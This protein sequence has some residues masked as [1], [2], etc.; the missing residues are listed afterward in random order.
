MD[1][2]HTVIT[3]TWLHNIQW[4]DGWKFIQEGGSIRQ[5]SL[6]VINPEPFFQR[7]PKYDGQLLSSDEIARA[8]R[9]H[10]M[11]HALRFK[12]VHTA[13]RL[14]LGRTTTSDPTALWFEKGR[15]NKP[16]LKRPANTHIQFNLSY[17]ENRAM[18]GLNSSGQPIG[19]DIEWSQRLLNIETMLKACFSANEITFICAKESEMHHRFFTLWTRKE[20]ILKLTGEGIGEHL[21]HFEVLDGMYRARKQVIGRQPPDDVYLYSFSP[22]EGFIGCLASPIPITECFFY[23]L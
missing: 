1:R 13:L 20:A 10:Q 3:S 12:A 5:P 15:H 19:V 2:D 23:R 22:E 7:L 14:L 9:F 18:I 8:V 11:D 6:W 4:Q 17:T 21:P 16:R